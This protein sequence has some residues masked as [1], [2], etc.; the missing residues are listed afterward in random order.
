MKNYFFAFL[1][2]ASV[3]ISCTPENQISDE[4]QID[5]HKVC[6]PGDRNCNG[7]LDNQE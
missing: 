6:P 2:L 5:K 1:M 7:V 3:I 4:Q